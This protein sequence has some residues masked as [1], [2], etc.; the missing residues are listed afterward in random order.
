[1]ILVPHI[2]FGL[3]CHAVLCALTFEDFRTFSIFILQPAAVA[4]NLATTDQDAMGSAESL[5]S[6]MSSCV[7]LP[8]MSYEENF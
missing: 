6:A 3:P 2:Q 5:A 4:T 8:S 7:Q 1:M